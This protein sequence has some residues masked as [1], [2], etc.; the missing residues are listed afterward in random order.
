MKPN[1]ASKLKKFLL[2]LYLS[3]CVWPLTDLVSEYCACF[4][5]ADVGKSIDRVLITHPLQ[6]VIKLTLAS[7]TRYGPVLLILMIFMT[8]N[9]V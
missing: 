2:H 6:T 4:L 8:Q 7:F 9:G 1:F 3:V 5:S